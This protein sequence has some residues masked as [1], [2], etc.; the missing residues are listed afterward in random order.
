[1]LTPDAAL[2]RL[3]QMLTLA[4]RAGADAADAVYFGEASTG[5]GV[6]LGKL[7]EIGRSEGEEIGLRMFLGARSAQVSV[8]DLSQAALAEAVDRVRSM[9]EQASE[10]R[11]AGLAPAEMLASGPFAQFDLFDPTADGISAERL[12]AMALEAEDA[13]RAMPQISNSEGG[14]ASAGCSVSALATSTGFRGAAQGTSISV[15]AV[16]VAGTD[17]AKQRDYDWHQARHLADLDTPALVGRRAGERAAQRLA[18]TKAP[19]GPMPVVFD[20]RV[21][22]SL[23]GHLMSAISGSAIARKT[24]FLLGHEDEPIFAPGITVR[25]DPHR[26]RGLRSRAFDAEGLPTAARDIIADG[27]LTGWLVDS[28]AGRQLGLPPTGHAARGSAG[29]PG[30]S[31]SNLWLEAGAVT[32]Q[33]MISDIKIGIYVTELIGMGVNTLTGDYSRGAGGFMIRDGALA[34]PVSEATIAGHLLAMFRALVPANDLVFRQST[35]APTV[36]IDGMTVAG[37]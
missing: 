34:E 25:D 18:P 8:S 12:Q 6:R 27:R 36:R 21:S 31:P 33:E 32:P 2:D 26:L 14:S 20:Q 10:D 7:E 16:V 23:V 37:E 24:S 30:V 9:A 3:D 22:A 5:I 13:A 29:P 17:E 1:M 11:Y 4:R 15:S 28:A 19:T 35:N